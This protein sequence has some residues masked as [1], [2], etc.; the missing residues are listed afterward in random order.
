MKLGPFETNRIYKVDAYETIKLLP[1]NS[2]D[3]IITDPP[4]E[5]S[6]AHGSGAFGTEKKLS[7]R[8]IA[9]ISC[10]IDYAILDDFVRVLKDINLYIWCSKRQIPKLIEYFVTERKCRYE[11]ITWHKTNAP[12]TCNSHYMLDTEYCL[13]F[14]GRG[15]H[16]Y[17]TV[18]S[19]RTYYVTPTNV[20][21]KQ[22]FGHPTIK[23]LEIIQNFVIN[24]SVGGGY[25]I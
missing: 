1:D 8:Q 20:L 13:Y 12:P 23:P 3:L 9:D 25:R 19:K 10:G 17:G 21:D 22:R 24:S 15:V 4:Y 7:F 14:R 5:Q 11:I 6:V 16:I 2:I 18:A